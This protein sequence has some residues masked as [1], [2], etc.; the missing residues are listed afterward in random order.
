MK[1]LFLSL[2]S[3]F[4]KNSKSQIQKKKNRGGTVV[5]SNLNVYKLMEYT[6]AVLASE[7]TGV[8]ITGIYKVC[9]NQRYSAGGYKWKYK[10]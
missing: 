6:N 4:K 1:K 3:L 2:L 9:N 5:Q 8:G 7:F 10:N